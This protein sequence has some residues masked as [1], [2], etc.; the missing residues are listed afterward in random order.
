[1]DFYGFAT[2][3]QWKNPLQNCDFLVVGPIGLSVIVTLRRSSF[4]HQARIGLCRIMY[5][6]G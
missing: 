3:L 6:R 5:A 2:D 4:S 1:M